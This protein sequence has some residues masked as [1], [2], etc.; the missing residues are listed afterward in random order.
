MEKSRLS[1]TWGDCYGYLLIATGWADVMYDPLMNLWD[2]AAL[3]PIVRGAGGVITDSK[4]GP[5][6]P[7]TSTV[8]SSCAEVHEQV[9]DAL[10]G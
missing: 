2:I 3:V 4:G 5:A 1:R 6:Y 7:A 8:A 10:G 9:L